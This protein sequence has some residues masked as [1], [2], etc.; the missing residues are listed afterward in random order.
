[1]TEYQKASRPDLAILDALWRCKEPITLG[2][3]Y[4]HVC[5]HDKWISLEAVGDRLKELISGDL[6]TVSQHPRGGG[7]PVYA[8][9]CKGR[10]LLVSHKTDA[11]LNENVAPA[12]A[13]AT[14]CNAAE[15]PE[16][17]EPAVALLCVDEDEL[18][19]WWDAL[20]VEAKADAFAQWSLGNDGRNSH[21]Y[22]EPC[23]AISIPVLGSAGETVEE[24]K[25][26]AEPRQ[27]HLARPDAPA[28]A[29]MPMDMLCT[30]CGER[31]GEWTR[32]QSSTRLTRKNQRVALSNDNTGPWIYSHYCIDA[33]SPNA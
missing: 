12:P 22:I 2:V 29:P 32:G 14:C 28:D 15:P 26:K 10:V 27:P 30:K 13:R 19:D 8:I 4:K 1:M 24:W 23:A 7:A 5:P 16:E 3:L 6:V 21:I 11:V 17:H 18:N 33:V 20:D 31:G 25:A 9:T